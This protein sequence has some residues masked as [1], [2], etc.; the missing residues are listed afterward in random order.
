MSKLYVFGIG[1]TGSRV[2]RALTMLLASGAEC[3]ADTVVPIIIDPDDSAA[4]MT[5]TVELMDNYRAVHQKL[6]FSEA[7][8]NRFFFTK[9]KPVDNMVNYH[10]PLDNTRDCDFKGFIDLNSMSSENQAL[11]RMLFSKK[12]L[13]S[14]MKVGFKGNPNI[15][16]VVLNQFAGSEAYQNFANDFDDGDRIFIISSIFGGTGASGFPL[17]LK[18]LRNDRTSQKWNF[19]SKAHIGAVTI[20]PYFDVT[21]DENSGVDS[22][23]FIS[24]AKSALSYYERNISNGA[25]DALYYLGD[26]KRNTYENHDGGNKQRNNAHF[27]ELA[28]AMSILNFAATD[29]S[30]FDGQTKHYEYG[31][32]TSD[33]DIKTIIFDNLGDAS[34]SY[35][36]RPFSQFM[37]LYK[38]MKNS[39][40]KEYKHQPWA[41]DNGLDENFF[42]D[43]FYKKLSRVVVEYQAWLKEMDENERSFKPFNEDSVTPLFDL[44]AG[45]KERKHNFFLPNYVA[46]DKELNHRKHCSDKSA[47]KE[48]KFMEIFYNAT[49]QMVFKKFNIK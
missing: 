1:G 19:I 18:T 41:I 27:I 31:L 17:L 37:L 49:K 38:Y 3:K 40:E 11:V 5:R 22:A 43:D 21:Q 32:D 14:D 24:K 30:V 33:E 2:I 46:V 7:N 25:V 36:L 13:D 26:T 10:L 45:I 4:D 12:N 29:D 34:K 9:I 20:L 28:A 16:S 23:T 15:G 35:T 8:K 44:I 6:T 39:L 42:T 48:Q 47:P